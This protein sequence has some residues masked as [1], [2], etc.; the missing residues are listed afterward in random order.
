MPSFVG[1]AASTSPP[2]SSQVITSIDPFEIPLLLNML[3]V[4]N[5]TFDPTLQV[6]ADRK[7]VPLLKVLE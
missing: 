7:L 2:W 5:M 1:K 4:K 6:T 3:L